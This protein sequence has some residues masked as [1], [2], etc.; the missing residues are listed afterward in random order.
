MNKKLSVSMFVIIFAFVAIVVCLS[1]IS[2]KNSTQDVE[3]KTGEPI[4]TKD[5]LNNNE[6]PDLFT[7]N[8]TSH[9]WVWVKTLNGTG[10]EAVID[11]RLAPRKSGVFTISF[12]GDGQISGTTDCNNF[13]GTYT[14]I[15][16]IKPLASTLMFCEGS[17]ESEFLK[18]ITGGSISLGE[19]ELFIE[20]DQT[21]FFSKGEKIK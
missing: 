12:K 14:T 13:S 6:S 15:G 10:P 4:S 20:R 1:Y 5:V 16:E 17:Q 8:L 21:L 18:M 11:E 2:N 3:I 7:E 9:K 19:D